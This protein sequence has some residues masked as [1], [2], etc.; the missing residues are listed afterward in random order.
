MTHSCTWAACRHQRTAGT[1]FKFIF[2]RPQNQ[3]VC[4]FCESPGPLLQPWY[5]RAQATWLMWL[6]CS[7]TVQPQKKLSAKQRSDQFSKSINAR[8]KV[9]RRPCLRNSNPNAASLTATSSR[10]RPPR[11][12]KRAA[13]SWDRGSSDFS[14]SLSSVPVSWLRLRGR[15][16][17]SALAGLATGLP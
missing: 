2:P 16:Y 5:V 17:V 8:G 7:V 11:R 13:P 1:H 6:E 10:L 3:K 14:S 4:Q 12:K 15:T 9:R